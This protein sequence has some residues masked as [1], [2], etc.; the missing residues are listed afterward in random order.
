[1]AE[2][3]PEGTCVVWFTI[4]CAPYVA[5]LI[6]WYEQCTNR[7]LRETTHACAFIYWGYFYEKTT[8]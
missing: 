8:L 1:M 3:N 2:V 7:F 6:G 5:V 4:M